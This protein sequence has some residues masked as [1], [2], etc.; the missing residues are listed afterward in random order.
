MLQALSMAA[1]GSL[2]S[3]SA[4]INTIAD[5]QAVPLLETGVILSM[6]SIIVSPKLDDIQQCI[7][8]AVREVRLQNVSTI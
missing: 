1:T 5:D 4:R 3:L 8:A 2:R 6:P 7:S